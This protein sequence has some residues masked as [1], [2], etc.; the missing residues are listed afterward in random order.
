MAFSPKLLGVIVATFGILSFLCGIVAENKKP[1]AGKPIEG[2]GVVICKYQSDPTVLLGYLSAAFLVVSSAVGYFSVFY[3]YKGKSIPQA[4]LF[5]NCTFAAFFNVALI[6]TVFAA[7]LLLWTTIT[8]H[9][10]LIHNVHHNL[11]T[12][13]PTAKTGVFGGGAFVSLDSSLFWLLSLMLVFNAREDYFEEAE[14]GDYSQVV[15]ID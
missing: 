10:H 5:R 1:L 7:G 12:D 4:A 13:C 3:P 11:D 2:K 6:T 9:L 8:E 14:K 15:S